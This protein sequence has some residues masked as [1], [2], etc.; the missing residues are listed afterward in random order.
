MGHIQTLHVHALCGGVVQR[1]PAKQ[2]SHAILVLR[3]RNILELYVEGTP[4]ACLLSRYTWAME[5]AWDGDGID[6]F[7]GCTKGTK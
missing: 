6:G 4:Y 5:A 3:E 1:L 7:L 2:L